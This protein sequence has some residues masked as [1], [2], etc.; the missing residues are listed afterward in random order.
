MEDYGFEYSEEE[1]EQQNVDTEN[2]YYNAKDRLSGLQ[3]EDNLSQPLQAFQEVVKMD[4][5]AADWSFKAL[6]QIVKLYYRMHK[7][8]EML[9]AYREMLT[10]IK[11]AVTR[12]ASEK[13]INSLLDFVSQSTDMNLLQA[14][15]STTL[16]ALAEAKNERLWFKTQL[17][18]C[19]L[20]FK[21]NEYSRLARILKELHRSCQT[22]DGADDVKKGT[23]LLEVY[24]LEI[25]LHSAQKNSKRL[26]ELYTRALTIKSAIPHPRIMGIIRECGGKMHMHERD[27]QEAA[28]DFFEAFKNYDEAGVPRRVQCLKYLVLASMLM[29][30]SVDPFDAQE[31]KP[32]KNDSQVIAMTDLV[33]AYQSNDI[34]AFEKILATNKATIYDDLFIRNYIEDL[35]RNIRTQVVLAMVGP[36]TRIRIPFISQKLNIPEADVEQLLVALI[37]DNK[38]HGRIDQVNQ[39][40]ELDSKAGVDV[41]YASMDKW[42]KH[43]QAVH[44][45]VIARLQ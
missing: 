18:L 41:K 2:T 7:H 4:E 16:E 14:F 3:D 32:Y 1:D 37:L 28:T 45:T 44:N 11:S 21:L 34:S 12:N 17:K 30:S 6:K 25:Q 43:L 36:Y 23:Q 35:L 33:A 22:E 20:W 31:A 10:Y 39:Q 15:Y 8:K 5:D 38:I 9:E 29:G 19:G 13:K 24:A 26:K 42:A 40:L 27:W